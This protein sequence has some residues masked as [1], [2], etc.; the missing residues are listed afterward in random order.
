MD[1]NID[2]LVIGG[3]VNGA[4]IARDAAGRGLSVVLVDQ[5]DLAG[6]TS[7]SS[8]KLI[9]G[10][11]RYLEYYEFRLVRE[12]LAERAVLLR[13]APHIA[14]PMRFVLPHD[15]SMRPAWMVRLGLFLYDHL[16]QG[17]RRL[18]GTR[19]LDLRHG[20]EGA[21]L[22][23][24]FT[25]GFEYSDAW[26]DDARLVVLNAMDAAERGAAIRPRTRCT[27]LRAE[28]AQW[29]ATL[30][31]GT[32]L[33]AR[34]VVN[35]AGPWV[36]E[37]LHNQAGRN[38]GPKA[39]LVK[40]SHIVVP[41]LYE[42]SQAYILQNDDR[43][44]VFVLPYEQDFSLIGTTDVPF[45]GDPA[46][47]WIDTDEVAYLCRAVSRVFRRPVQP[48]DM[49]HSFSGVRPLQDSGEDKAAAVTRD[50][51]LHL[52]Q[53]PAPML[54][55]FGGKIT[56]YRRLAEHAMAMLDPLLSPARPGAWTAT[57][58][59]P[60]G[61]IPDFAAFLADCRRRYAFLPDA[62]LTRLAHA[63]GSRLP[64]VLGGA[65]D[66]AGLGEHFGAGLYAAELRYLREH[67]WART[68]EDVLW[69]RSKLGLRLDPAQRARV[70]AAMETA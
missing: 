65:T 36:A 10:G 50:Y 23:E 12:A 37:V 31:D 54:S 19:R 5:G 39:R 56:T 43:R 42:G 51:K 8:S 27:A 32:T 30:A 63:Y 26:V 58:P 9:H 64:A 61:D 59:L 57:Q 2:L 33:R 46:Q 40:G 41:R 62:V 55:V 66:L 20:P 29:I 25:T 14:W 35:A 48:S 70:A 15:R 13:L 11:L 28:G 17:R 22:Q 38:Q 3:G 34:A 24:Q 18:P 68:G 1:E 69:R 49:V 53:E 4:G 44:I 16:G 67:E 52:E 60:G 47:V 7:S 45:T 6:A 21:P